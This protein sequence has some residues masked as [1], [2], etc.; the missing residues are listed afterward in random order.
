MS[1][2]SF[3]CSAINP[4]A[5]SASVRVAQPY[6]FVFRSVLSA[7][8]STTDRQSGPFD[9]VALSYAAHNTLSSF[10]PLLAR[11]I[12]ATLKTVLD[13]YPLSEAD[14]AAAKQIGQSAAQDAIQ[15]HV[16]DGSFNYV[17]YSGPKTQ[18][19]SNFHPGVYLPTPPANAYPPVDPQDRY[20]FTSHAPCPRKES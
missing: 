1:M 18:N 2:T 12:D 20:V 19:D 4:T 13:T 15:F 7:L 5:P 17:A 3:H 16:G 14:A 6:A 9:A 10:Y 11:Q 8:K